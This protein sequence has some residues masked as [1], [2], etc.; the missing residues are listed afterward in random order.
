LEYISTATVLNYGIPA[1]RPTVAN[2]GANQKTSNRENV[3]TGSFRI[4]PGAAA[5]VCLCLAGTA[6]AK[7]DP[8]V[9]GQLNQ[10][11]G[12][13]SSQ[14]AK[15]ETPEGTKGGAHGQH[16]RSTQ[17]ADRNGGFANS[18]NGFGITFNVKEEGETNAGRLGVGNATRAAPHN[19]EPGDGGNG[20][21]AINNSSM[22]VNGRVG[23]SRTLN[24]VTGQFT[25]EAGGTAEVVD[26]SCDLVDAP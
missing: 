2:A 5:V 16:S 15:L 23:A 25:T 20:Q 3:M 4:L 13:I 18:N 21:H 9:G 12:Q 8:A 11:W 24:P 19:A 22:I 14:L 6:W 1:P 10:C 26:L 7:Q 17:A